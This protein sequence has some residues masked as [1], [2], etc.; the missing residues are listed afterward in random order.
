MNYQYYTVDPGLT[1]DKWISQAEV[2]AG[3]P[4]VVHHVIVFIQQPG[5]QR[6]GAPQMALRRA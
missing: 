1:E 2:K 4:A 5:G 3:N 6:F